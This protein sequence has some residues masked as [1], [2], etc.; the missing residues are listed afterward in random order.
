ML[1]FRF[2]VFGLLAPAGTPVTIVQQL[3]RAINEGLQSAEVRASLDA[4]GVDARVGAADQ[5]AAALE[6]Q[7]RQ[8]KAVIEETGIKME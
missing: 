6:Q 3:N 4:L 5:F 2:H 1:M 7:A 8:R